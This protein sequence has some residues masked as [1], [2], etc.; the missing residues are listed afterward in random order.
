LEAASAFLAR[1]QKSIYSDD[2]QHFLAELKDVRATAGMSQEQL[3]TALGEHQ[4]F[5]SKVEVGVRR[6]DVIELRLWLQA[7]GTSLPEFCVELDARLSRH[8]R[9]SLARGRR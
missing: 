2:Y 3:A 9:P 5:I 7:L 6:L 4:T 8:R 1:M